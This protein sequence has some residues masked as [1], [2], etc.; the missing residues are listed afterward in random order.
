M[1]HEVEE[2]FEATHGWMTK[3]GGGHG[4]FHTWRRRWFYNT[5]SD[6]LT[7]VYSSK[8]D[9]PES[10]VKG[11]IPLREMFAIRVFPPDPRKVRKT[12]PEKLRVAFQI[13]TTDR[14]FRFGILF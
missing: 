3:E 13:S 11:E 1:S 5:L 6:E 9:R 2:L 10:N 4:G 12:K 14:I 8:A 7:L